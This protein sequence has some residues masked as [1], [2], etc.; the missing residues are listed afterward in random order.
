MSHDLIGLVLL[1]AYAPLL[2]MGLLWIAAL[3]LRLAGRPG[4]LQWLARRT[5]VPQPEEAPHDSGH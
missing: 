5:S 4:F 3:A 1:I 2:L